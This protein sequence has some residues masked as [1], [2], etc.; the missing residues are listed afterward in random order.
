M[1]ELLAAFD[2]VHEKHEAMK[3]EEFNDDGTY[4]GGI[5]QVRRVTCEGGSTAHAHVCCLCRWH[6]RGDEGLR[7]GAL[8]SRR[9]RG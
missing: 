9:R 2:A 6:P 7:A 3:P 8:S 5:N 4:K 1:A